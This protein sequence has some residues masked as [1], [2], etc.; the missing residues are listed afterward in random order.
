MHMR[1]LVCLLVCSLAG[2]SEPDP[3]VFTSATAPLAPRLRDDVPT[4]GGPLRV[5]SVEERV[6]IA[7][8]GELV[9]V[10]LFLHDGEPAEPDGFVL[11]DQQDTARATPIPY[12]ADDIRRDDAG[13][14]SRMHLYFRTDLAAWQRRRFVLLPGRNPGA[15]LP[16]VAVRVA[17]GEVTLGG[18]DLRVSFR[19]AGPRAG[20]I[21]ALASNVGVLAV[22]DGLAPS[23]T[24]V[25]QDVTCAVVRSTPVSYSM[26][27]G[28]EVRAL[29]WASGPLF[30]KLVVCI[31]PTGVPDNAEYTYH[32]PAHGAALT[33]TQRLF[34]SGP[35]SDQV[36]TAS[37]NILL[38]GRLALGA[39]AP[40][41]VDVPAGLRRLVR[42]VH[43]HTVPALVDRTAGISLL[44]APY[45]VT[46]ERFLSL[47][48]DGLV[49]VRGSDFRRNGDG[50]SGTL[51]ACWGQVR[52]VLSRTTDDDG[53]WDLMRANAQTLT[54]VVDEPGV[55]VADLSA[56]LTRVAPA[57]YQIK[58]WGRG[59][60][61][62]AAM[63]HLSGRT[64][65]V[66]KALASVAN[67]GKPPQRDETTL[68]HWL[69]AWAKP[70]DD[71]RSPPRPA[72]G[73]IETGRLDPYQ[74]SYSMSSIPMFAR[75]WSPGER[76][77]RICWAVGEASRRTNGVVDAYGS[78]QIACFASAL[79][80]QIGSAHHGIR[81]GLVTGD[82][83][84]VRF[85]RD[86][87][88][89]QGVTAVYG[90]GQ[91][92]YHS[93]LRDNRGERSDA[94]YQALSDLYL[95]AMEWS[96]DEDAWLHPT[97]FGRYGDCVD[98]TADLQHRT[99]AD[100]GKRLPSWWRGNFFRTQAHDHRWESWDA[101]PYLGALANT[102]DGSPTGLTDVCYFLRHRAGRN[103]NWS[104][105]MPMFH[106]EVCLT[107]G[108]A[109]WQPKPAPPL[110]SNV[111]VAD[112]RVGWTAP[113]GAGIVGYR[114]YRAAQMGGPWTFVNS[115]H[116]QPGTPA[117]ATGVLVT[118]TSF[119]DP[120]AGD[121]HVYWVTAVDQQGVESRWFPEEPTSRR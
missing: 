87:I 36:V 43:G 17:D 102:T 3:S 31:G 117:P 49:Q 63:D 4:P 92:P 110:P 116:S 111:R 37:D 59:W 64:A 24:L 38:A 86:L 62:H 70:G 68:G 54:A 6:G 26:P 50:N 56:E 23:L 25:R 46:G 76:L 94:L 20:S 30:A 85:Y 5:L 79:N 19:T 44:V 89:A 73:K 74:I 103:V 115:P 1:L 14:L 72:S 66:E 60:Q 11:Y 32:I 83:D 18:D 114:I 98:V 118:G 107:R 119:A 104:E 12:Q 84:L 53:L 77:E 101:L 96:C 22:P 7:R 15:G 2:A 39:T 55:T 48:D 81:G 13:R 90:R 42:R 93:R 99:L 61:Q 16:A 80:M 88:H 41:V 35:E 47:G 78:P 58:H 27:E 112:G 106:T 34:P 45:I 97:V 57:Y 10:P 52:L 21:S 71:G 121:G 65:A 100:D 33:I 28:V 40:A 69:P 8:Q 105:L 120:H 113:D 82:A 108:R 9:R 67:P 51:R 91:R 75:Y 29:R 95:R 109:A